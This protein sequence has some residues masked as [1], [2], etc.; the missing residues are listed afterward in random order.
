MASKIYQSRYSNFSPIASFILLGALASSCLGEIQD[1]HEESEKK[2]AFPRIEHVGLVHPN[3]LAIEF[4]NGKRIPGKYVPYIA[5]E[6]DEIKVQEKKPYSRTL[7]RNGQEIGYIVGPEGDQ[8]RFHDTFEGVELEAK[9]YF[10]EYL[11]SVRSNDDPAYKQSQTPV[12]TAL[13]SKPL[14]F[15]QSPGWIFSFATVVPLNFNQ[16]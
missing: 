16:N 9:D 14:D 7:H 4:I 6:G 10:L 11:Y 5:A 13:K 1:K 3:I 15:V 12:K 2:K 8:L